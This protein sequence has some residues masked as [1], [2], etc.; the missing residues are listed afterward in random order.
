MAPSGPRPSAPGIEQPGTIR[1]VTKSGV[2]SGADKGRERA[3]CRWCGRLLPDANGPGRPRRYCRQGCR[4]QAH[5]ARKLANAHG[6]G[7]D[8]VIIG[9]DALEELQGLLYCLQAAIEDVDR[10]LA[11]SPT[12]TDYADAIR[13]LLENARPLA[14]TWIEP[15]TTAE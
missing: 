8:D 11:G 12:K 3:R 7:D 13:W 4:Q 10:D 2:D 15:R 5:L 1:Q 6:L 14:T 9:R